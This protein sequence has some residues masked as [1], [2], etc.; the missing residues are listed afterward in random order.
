MSPEPNFTEILDRRPSEVEKP[1]PIPAGTYATVITGLPR[2]D[3][4]TKK[5]TPYVE[6]QHKI[7]NAGEDVSE[8]DLKEALSLPDGSVRSLQDIVMKNTYYLT[9]GAAWR[10]KEFLRDCGHDVENDT[11][12]LR[13]M[14][15]NCAGRSV[16]IFVT[17]VPSQDGQTVFAQIDK[18]VALD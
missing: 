18:T 7:V 15:E 12:S 14:V 6:F 1:K 16:G 4:S 9:E 8:D 11:M 10:L 5:Q 13:E 3:K 17:H 2:F